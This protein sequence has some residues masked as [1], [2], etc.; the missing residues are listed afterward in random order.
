LISSR[1]KFIKENTD[2]LF[3]KTKDA[4]GLEKFVEVVVKVLVDLRCV[5]VW[6]QLLHVRFFQRRFPQC[7]VVVEV[8]I[9]NDDEK[10]D[11]GETENDGK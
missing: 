8:T 7:R 3:K 1:V 9:S 4:N 6:V 2:R 5:D 10:P 11:E